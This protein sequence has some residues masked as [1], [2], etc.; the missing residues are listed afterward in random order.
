MFGIGLIGSIDGIKETDGDVDGCDDE[1]GIKEGV[2]EGEEDGADDDVGIEDGIEEIVGGEDDVGLSVMDGDVDGTPRL[3]SHGM[4][5]LSR[6]K[7]ASHKAYRLGLLSGF[8][9]PV[10]KMDNLQ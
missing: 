10:S 6:S 7:Y 1:V 2:E 3:G 9:P 8:H 5:I 4:S